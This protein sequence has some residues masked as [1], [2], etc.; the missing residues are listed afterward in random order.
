[1]KHGDSAFT[2][3]PAVSPAAHGDGRLRQ[4]AQARQALLTEGIDLAEALAS[5]WADRAWIL[6]S[7][8]R[9]LARGQQPNTP[10]AFDP[11]PSHAHTRA[12]DAHATLLAAA[13]PELQRLAAA[14]APIRYFVILTDAQGTVIDTA[15]A[16]DHR[17]RAI[18]AI[19]R[20]GVD[21]SEHHIGTSAIGAAL[22]ERAPVWL[23]R[24][25]HFF[26]DTAVYS[27]A[28]APLLGPDGACLGMI[29]V[30]GVNAPERPELKHL[31]AEAAQGIEDA[32][33]LARPHALRL[34]LAWPAG[35]KLSGGSAGTGLLCLDADG[36]LT[37]ANA[38]ARQMLPALQSLAHG[39]VHASELFALPWPQLFDLARHGGVATVPLWSGL[40]VQI[41]AQASTRP[42]HAA[43]A[44]AQTDTTRSLKA[45][46]A[47]LIHQAVREAGGRVAVAAKALG[48][49]RATVYRRLAEPS[50]TPRPPT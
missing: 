44:S 3:L 42:A 6:H 11:V 26:S 35:W 40:R 39:P 24:G 16:I 50:P 9:C 2:P 25:E 27:C 17:N 12:Q 19:A 36:Q 15:G 14:I 7:W 18:H 4:I 8:Q 45:L 33:V 38:T 13:R 34:R 1:M 30:T 28:G 29:D 32:L 48:V 23:H 31:V 5:T 37:G 22:A 46:E 41:D 43:P 20:V 21:L 10:V 47:H 49:S